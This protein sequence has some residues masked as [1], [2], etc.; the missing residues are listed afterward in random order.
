MIKNEFMKFNQI[1][2]SNTELTI[3][4][5]IRRIGLFERLIAKNN[6]EEPDATS[7]LT[8]KE[9][10]AE[11]KTDKLTVRINSNGGSVSEGLAIYNQ[12]SD[13]PGELITKV[14]GFAASAASV[15]FMAG[16]K[17]IVPN[18][19]LLMIHNAWTYG[20][21]DSKQLRKLADDLEKITQPSVD[22]YV[23]KTGQEESTIKAM[24]DNET[25]ITSK[26]AVDLGFATQEVKASVEMSFQQNAMIS[27][28]K[29][30][31]NLKQEVEELKHKVNMLEE[32]K[33]KIQAPVSKWEGF[34]KL[35]KG[36]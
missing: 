9:A 6:D 19:S 8:F 29:G 3:Y 28:V 32:E 10:L 4:G 31:K 27:L 34:F 13:F 1:D 18:S 24:M 22:V 26:E 30:N 35:E 5:D 15:I 25:W 23:E 33:E 2:E 12:L 11:V 7:A 21:G 17:R 14:D 20:E 16:T 36:E